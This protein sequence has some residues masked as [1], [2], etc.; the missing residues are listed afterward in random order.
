MRQE[1]IKPDIT[2]WNSLIRWHC[3]AGDSSKALKLFTQMLEQGLYPDPKI[4]IT[5]ISH[6]GEQ[7]KWDV[8]KN[9]ETMKYRGHKKSGAIYAVL[10]D[11]YGQYGRFDD[12]EVC[13]SALKSEGVQPSASIFCLSECLC[14]A[15]PLLHTPHCFL[16]PFF[17][18]SPCII[19]VY[20]LT[21]TFFLFCLWGVYISCSS[22][23]RFRMILYSVYI[24]W[25]HQV[26]HD[27]MA[28]SPAASAI[29]VI[30]FSNC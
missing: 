9:F 24:I 28:S 29:Y 4:F 13:I 5:I 2:T 22:L 16:L 11:I 26:N 30:I 7:G 12:A 10:V 15:G 23:Y 19:I 3:K 20:L 25:A 17:L 8:M 21:S 18:L 14:S 27:S 1:G 6:L